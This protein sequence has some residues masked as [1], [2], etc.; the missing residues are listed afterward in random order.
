MTLTKRP[1]P[2]APG[3]AADAILLDVMMP[4][5]DGPTTVGR[6]QADPQ[7]RDI[8]VI[9]LTAKVQPADRERFEA[10][11]V[12]AVLAKPFDPMTLPGQISDALGWSGDPSGHAQSG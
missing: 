4:G 12:A 8:P 3:G 6:L 5:L 7:T 10:L 1:S 2:V 9:L 11:G